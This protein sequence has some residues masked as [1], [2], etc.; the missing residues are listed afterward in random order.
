[1]SRPTNDDSTK[2]VQ[3]QK[4]QGRYWNPIVQHE[5]GGCGAT[6]G[7]F[8]ILYCDHERC[9]FCLGQLSSCGCCYKHFYPEYTGHLWPPR[10]LTNNL[11]VEVYEKGLPPEQEAEWKRILE[12]K[13]RVRY[14]STPNLCA[15]CGE[16]WPQMFHVKDWDDVIPANIRNEM[17]CLRCY[18]VVKNFVEM[19]KVKGK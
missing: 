4:P 15:R 9:P 13:G 16:T 11:P 5:C 8:H 7:Q 3:E 12:A 10:H 19:A 2:A 18:N 6:E 17:L 14:I 1:M